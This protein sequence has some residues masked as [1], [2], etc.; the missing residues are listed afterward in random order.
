MREIVFDTE[1][2]GLSPEKGDRVI[3]IGALELINRVETGKYF[4]T[5]FNPER[6]VHPDAQAVH[7]LSDNFLADKPLFAEKVEDLL[8]F[9]QDSPLVAHNAMFDLNFLNNELSLCGR[10]NISA[11]RVIDTLDIA[12]KRHPGAR[13]S[14]D[15]LC[16][17]YGVDRSQRTKHGALLDSQL[18][19]QIYV[20]MM[21]GGL[22]GMNEK[23][24]PKKAVAQE[25]AED[26]ILRS[27]P[28]RKQIVIQPSAQQRE[29]HRA[30]IAQMKDPIWLHG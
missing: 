14:L 11:N 4:H 9:L 8:D 30:F 22:L 13:N 1:T 16:V 26:D 12:R 20:E 2:T 24:A 5:Y 17:R 10:F 21:G 18:L 27:P 28:G 3:E 6:N 19:A 7:G 23:A 15:A 25:V 29:A